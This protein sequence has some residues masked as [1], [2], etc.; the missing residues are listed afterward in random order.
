MGVGDWEKHNLSRAAAQKPEQQSR[1]RVQN[2]GL[3]SNQQKSE[4]GVREAMALR[5]LV[6]P[7]AQKVKNEKE[8]TGHQNRVNGQFNPKRAQTLGSAFL[9]PEFQRPGE[10][11]NEQAWQRPMP[12]DDVLSSLQFQSFSSLNGSYL[13]AGC[14]RR[15]RSPN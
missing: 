11:S 5:E 2:N 7:F 10:R 6:Q 13:G 8:I 9:H 14:V 12:G 4:R 1:H 15:E 3:A